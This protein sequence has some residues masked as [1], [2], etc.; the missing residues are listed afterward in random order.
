VLALLPLL[1]VVFAVS[2]SGRFASNLPAGIAC[3][4]AGGGAWLVAV[5]LA[6][7][8]AGD[9]RIVV[10]GA[11]AI[12]ILAWS[13]D[14]GL[15]DDI[16]RCL[17]EGEIVVEGVSPYST[18][19]EDGS[20][21]GP[22]RASD[23]RR[24]HP[25]LWA[26]VN[27]KEVRAAYPPLAQSVGAAVAAICRRFDAPPET[28]GVRILRAIFGVC[29]LLVL[30]PLAKL[31]RRA[32]L[33][34]SLGVVWAWCPLPAVEFA[35]SGHV[36]SLGILLLLAALAAGTKS[37]RDR[38]RSA[39]DATRG[40]V[41]LALLC[42]GV[43]TKYLPV[44]ALPWLLRGR[45]AISKAV[46]IA[47][48]CAA[49]FAPLFFLQGTFHG[50]LSGLGEYAFRWES[51]SLV[52]RWIEPLF[53]RCFER[54]ESWSDP[55]RLAR[56]SEAILWL[57][58]AWA[59]IRRDRDALRGTGTL[60]G[61]W[62]VLSPTLHP[63]YLCWIIPFLPFGSPTGASRAWL[64][65]ILVAPL[66]YWPL[67]QWQRAGVWVEPAWLWPLVALPFFGLLVGA[68]WQHRRGRARLPQS[69]GEE[70]DA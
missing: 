48:F 49:G 16:Y 32:R 18:A 64:W 10:A 7:R 15:S 47:L 9:P 67:E 3:M 24:R 59:V 35:G 17:W 13:G 29:D 14:A 39:D 62:L 60:I 22:T 68:W 38:T 21:R 4:I 63:W 25:D 61:A 58:F 1:G 66:L 36:D 30:W 31:L 44:V 53:S 37:G 11:I 46:C 41:P 45:K 70:S 65:T 19:P 40:L 2:A 20:D 42:A 55:R 12:R 51:G 5:H 56:A 34:G 8:G 50:L 43:L 6:R 28:A 69:R 23:L 52:H 26:R 27:H 57:C 54:D 33:P